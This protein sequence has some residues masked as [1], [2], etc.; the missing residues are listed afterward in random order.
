MSSK[1]EKSKEV[2]D[3]SDLKPIGINITSYFN[4]IPKLNEKFD[5]IVEKLDSQSK[6]LNEKYD[7]LDKKYDNLEKSITRSINDLR[8]NIIKKIDELFREKVSYISVD[9]TK[10]NINKAFYKYEEQNDII[11]EISQSISSKWIKKNLPDFRFA[12]IIYVID[13]MLNTIVNLDKK[14]IGIRLNRDEKRSYI[15]LCR[16]LDRYWDVIS[17]HLT[18]FL[19]NDKIKD[20]A[21]K[22]FNLNDE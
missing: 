14:L 13:Q 12:Q 1:R 20:D 8:D 11:G 19:V 10:K 16:H 2:D 15:A 17:P 9:C 6:E 4:A 3:I 5:D 22:N 7:K 21:I 18:P